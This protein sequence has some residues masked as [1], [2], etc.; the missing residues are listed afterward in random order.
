[1]GQ[2]PPLAAL[3]SRHLP[4][5]LEDDASATPQ[6]AVVRFLSLTQHTEIPKTTED[7]TRHRRPAYY[8]IDGLALTRRRE[9]HGP[10]REK[11]MNRPLDLVPK[12][13]LGSKYLMA[14]TGLGL[15]GF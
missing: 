10:R 1:M 15:V 6:A 2:R 9:Q 3:R 8:L 13:S 11:R 7:T 14:V 4:N 5:R 12:S